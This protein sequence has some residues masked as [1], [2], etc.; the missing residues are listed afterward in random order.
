M[1]SDERCR[2]AETAN[3]E[4]DLLS[5]E[6]RST[7]AKELRPLLANYDSTNV[8]S[9]DVLALENPAADA[10]YFWRGFE[11]SKPTASSNSSR[12]ELQCYQVE[13]IKCHLKKTKVTSTIV[14][15]KNFFFFFC[16]AIEN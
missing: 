10:N 8:P 15:K 6:I 12:Y 16:T 3:E 11:R 7:S 9:D 2:R 4:K 1:Y 5:S 14:G 13:N